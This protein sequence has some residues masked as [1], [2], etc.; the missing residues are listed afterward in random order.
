[1]IDYTVVP[2]AGLMEQ[3]QREDIKAV[4]KKFSCEAEPDLEDFLHN[5]AMAYEDSRKG[6]TFLLI[7]GLD[8]MNVIAYY[9]LG[10]TSI[11]LSEA[12]PKKKKKIMGDFPD[13]DHRNFFP[14][15]LIGQ[16]GRCDNYSHEDLPGETILSEAYHTLKGAATVIG[17]KL[18]VLE[19]RE[20]M[21]KKVYEG[22]DYKKMQDK[23]TDNGLYMLYRRV[24][25]SMY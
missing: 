5:K 4:L 6:S 11:D 16:I 2:L 10:N 18:V 22:L 9:T 15:Y 25:F 21:Y 3:L 19:C 1:M 8:S 14:A 24:D 7:D 13:R 23:L 20:H 17:G 12:K